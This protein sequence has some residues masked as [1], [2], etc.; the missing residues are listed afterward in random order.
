MNKKRIALIVLLILAV[1]TVLAYADAAPIPDQGRSIGG[2]VG[3]AIAAVAALVA[4]IKREAIK[5]FFNKND[6]KKKSKTSGKF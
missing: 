5:N 1:S 4:V 3:A 2:Y 6:A